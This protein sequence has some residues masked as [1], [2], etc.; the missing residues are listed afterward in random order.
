MKKFF[1]MLLALILVCSLCVSAFATSPSAGGTSAVTTAA[2]PVTE[3]DEDTPEVKGFAICETATDDVVKEVPADQV[4]MVPV[5]EADELEEADKEAFLAAYEDVKKIDDAVVKYFFWLG[6]PEE[7]T[8]GEGQYFRFIFVCKGENVRVTVNGEEMKVEP[9]EGKE[10][11]YLAKLT[12]LGAVA[13]LC[14][15]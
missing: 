13:I 15:K 8:P 12:K 10:D 5:G 1:S 7:Y 9:V 11:T 3:E 4:K 6:A 14:D 2:L